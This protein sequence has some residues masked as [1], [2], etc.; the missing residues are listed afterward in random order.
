MDARLYQNKNE[1]A[2]LLYSRLELVGSVKN[3][4]S[5]TKCKYLL[6]QQSVKDMNVQYQF[7]DTHDTPTKRKQCNGQ[8]TMDMQQKAHHQPFF[9][10]Q[11][12]RM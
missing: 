1:G 2:V 12:R 4:Y 11:A 7:G 10:L 9:R 5:E 3:R 6:L 8:N